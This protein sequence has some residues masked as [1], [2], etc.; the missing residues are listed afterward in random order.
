MMGKVLEL[1]IGYDGKIRSVKL[2]QGNGS[3]EYHSIN[4]LYPLELSVTHAVR[5]NEPRE[6]LEN[7]QN[8]MQ[9]SQESSPRVGES[10]R[11]K[12]K[13]TERFHRIMEKNIGNL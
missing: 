9:A 8:V 1:I 2:K 6:A 11:P 7:D 4:N 5:D 12:R 10:V 13:A 3:V